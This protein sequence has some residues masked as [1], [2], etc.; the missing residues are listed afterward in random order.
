MDRKEMVKALGEH[1]GVKPIYLGVP[2]CNYQIETA[3]GNYIIDRAG[4]I[5]DSEGNRI[6][7]EALL[8]GTVAEEA[9]EPEAEIETDEITGLEISV[10]MNGHTGQ[11][12]RNLVNMIYSKQTLIKKALEI[13]EDI[14]TEELIQAINEAKVGTIEEFKLV[15]EKRGSRAI[16]FNF[17]NNRITFKLYQEKVDSEKI[18]AYTQLVGLMNQQGKTLRYASARVKETDNEKFTFRVWIIRLGMI[19]DEYKET[20]KILLQNLTGNSAFRYGKP[21]KETTTGE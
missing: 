7:F 21:E 17:D 18:N 20:R 12:L 14:V 19:G 10:P 11:T 6:G 9:L 16:D 3:T 13:D 5:T 15:I 2:S 4:K 1:F 8:N